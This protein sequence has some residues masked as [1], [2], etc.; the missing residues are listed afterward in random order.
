MCQKDSVL[1]EK[2]AWMTA[3]V[4]WNVN[5]EWVSFSTSNLPPSALCPPVPL[6]QHAQGSEWVLVAQL[7]LTLCDPVDCSLPGSSVYGI[8]QARI[9]EWVAIPV[10]RGSSRLR[11]W[12]WVSCIAGRFFHRLSHQ[13]SPN[14]HAYF[15]LFFFNGQSR[16]NYMVHI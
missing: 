13:G 2:L 8:L 7:Y 16:T 11:Y 12:T 4:N 5:S 9:L 3:F 10:S 6:N 14:H 15:R 1:L